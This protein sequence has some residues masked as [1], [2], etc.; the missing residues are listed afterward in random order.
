MLRAGKLASLA[1]ADVAQPDEARKVAEHAL[2]E[3]ARAALLGDRVALRAFLRVVEPIVRRVCGG[4]MGRNSPDI[5]DA[6]QD[7]LIDVARGLQHFR[8]ECSAAHYVTKIA[9]RRAIGSRRRAQARW[10]QHATLDIDS[11]AAANSEGAL[12]ARADRL[13]NLLD[14]LNEAQATALLLRVLMGHSID[15]ISDITGV[16]VNTVK[17]RLRLGKIQLR[18]WLKRRGEHR[19]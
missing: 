17:T 13:R 14:E 7:S 4:V 5:E 8:F 3:S 18:R 16:S 15:E 1:R 12:D 10:K 11:L 19:E 9:L 6:I 2:N